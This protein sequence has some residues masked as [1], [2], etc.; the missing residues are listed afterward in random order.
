[1]RERETCD[2]SLFSSKIRFSDTN[3]NNA[4]KRGPDKAMKAKGLFILHLSKKKLFILVTVNRNS[5]KP[6]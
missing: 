6:Q 2:Y 5:Y 3:T 4:V 1:M